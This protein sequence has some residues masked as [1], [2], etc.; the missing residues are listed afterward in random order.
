MKQIKIYIPAKRNGLNDPEDESNYL[1]AIDKRDSVLTEKQY[2]EKMKQEKDRL[3]RQII[4]MIDGFNDIL[5]CILDNEYMF[6]MDSEE[7]EAYV[8]Y[9]FSVVTNLDYF[10]V[11]IDKEYDFAAAEKYAVDY[12]KNWLTDEI[13]M[14]ANMLEHIEE[15]LPQLIPRSYIPFIVELDE[16]EEESVDITP[17][18]N[19]QEDTEETTE[20]I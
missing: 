12:F 13:K 18:L 8:Y 5:A 20:E 11:G 16:E 15:Y 4:T 1:I 3:I 19:A 14:R 6:I 17:E 10:V 2:K 7:N 9:P